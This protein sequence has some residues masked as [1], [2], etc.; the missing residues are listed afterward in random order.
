MSASQRGEA[1][2]RLKLM[3]APACKMSILGGEPTLQPQL[4]L[5]AV[6]DAAS[7]GFLVNVV[8]NGYA[9]T[10]R[11]IIQLGNAGLDH[12]AVSVDV[13]QPGAL[14][15]DL[16]KALTLLQ[17]ARR[18]GI[19]PVINVLVGSKTDLKALKAFCQQVFDAGCFVSLLAMSPNVGGMFSSA[20]REEVPTNGQLREIVRWLKRK[21][22]FT[23]LATSTFGYLNVLSEIGQGG[24]RS[25][26]HCADHFRSQHAGSG[27]GFLYVDSDGTLGPCQE[28]RS[29]LN[30]LE[31]P[32]ER[33]SLEFL[34]QELSGI[35]KRCEGCTYNCYIME[36]K[37]RGASVLAEI[38]TALRLVQVK[39]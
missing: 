4:I 11:L 16:E 27:R 39:S 3:S 21:K 28:F 12:L 33:L 17:V 18:Q 36:E 38:P 26:W 37:L 2:R 25:L 7:A 10:E 20:S 6:A 1:F 22:A 30:I 19:T 29:N 35:T 5:E 32:E 15:T 13:P 14:R 9:L 8:T 24:E 23:G 31:I 34:D